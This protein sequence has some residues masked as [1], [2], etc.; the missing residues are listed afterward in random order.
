MLNKWIIW[1]SLV[2]VFSSIPLSC[3]TYD[4]SGSLNSPA[5]CLRQ[6]T[7]ACQEHF[8]VD[9]VSR[10]TAAL[11]DNFKFYFSPQDVGT[12]F[13][14]FTIPGDWNST[15]E[16][17]AIN[18]LFNRVMAITFTI[19]LL[20]SDQFP[21]PPSGSEQFA[22][23]QVQMTF[24]VDL[25]GE[26]TLVATGTGDFVFAKQEDSRWKLVE[27]HDHTNET[28]DADDIARSIGSI[29][30]EYYSKHFK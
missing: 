10:Y 4:Y 15:Y 14:D 9:A 2:A 6:I 7:Q 18:E 12:V 1:L 23:N 13:G 24:T 21:S 16:Q 22:V 29:K 8:F 11:D 20:D 3:E 17:I 19:N 27:W 5:S 25:D 28:A 26:T 30:A